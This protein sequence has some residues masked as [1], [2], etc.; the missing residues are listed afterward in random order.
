VWPEKN[1][2]FDLNN[3]CLISS[4][5]VIIVEDHAVVLSRIFSLMILS[6]TI[7]QVLSGKVEVPRN[8]FTAGA[9]LPTHS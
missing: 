1:I 2:N 7:L 4:D 9:S 5:N 3:K 6:R 8:M